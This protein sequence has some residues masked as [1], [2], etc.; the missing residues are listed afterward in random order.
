MLDLAVVRAALQRAVSAFG[1]AAVSNR[2]NA[3]ASLI[4]DW[5]NGHATMPERKTSALLDLIG[6]IDKLNDPRS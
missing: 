5:M 3:P 2:L 6:E 4:R 1:I